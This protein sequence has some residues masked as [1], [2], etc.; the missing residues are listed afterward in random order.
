MKRRQKALAISNLVVRVLLPKV[1]GRF[2]GGLIFFPVSWPSIV[3]NLL[4]ETFGFSWVTY[5]LYLAIKGADFGA[6]S[7]VVAYLVSGGNEG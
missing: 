3:Q 2:A 1:M 4:V 6:G 7:V 5:F